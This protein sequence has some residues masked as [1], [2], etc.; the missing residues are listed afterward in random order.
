MT[1]AGVENRAGPKKSC[2][3]TAKLSNDELLACTKTT[4]EDWREEVIRERRGCA[5]VKVSEIGNCTKTEVNYDE[6]IVASETCYCDYA[7][8]NGAIN[9]HNR[10]AIKH[11]YL[12]MVLLA[13]LMKYS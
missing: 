6:Q 12:E 1:T 3:T 4:F 8:C 11:F 5:V 10:N 2:Q 7:L 13:Y 9:F